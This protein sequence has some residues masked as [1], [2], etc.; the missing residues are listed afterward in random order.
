MPDLGDIQIDKPPEAT[1]GK[2]PVQRIVIPAVLVLLAIAG[3]ALYFLLPSDQPPQ[4]PTVTETVAP[5]EPALVPTAPEPAPEAPPDDAPLLLPILDESD[6]V[7][8]ELA[9]VISTNPQLAAWLASDDLV[10]TFAVTVENV[11]DGA[12][13]SEHLEVLKP[14]DRFVTREDDGQT[15]IDERSYSRYDGLAAVVASLDADG[16]ARL[17]RNLEPLLGDAYRELGHPDADFDEA[18]EGA[19]RTLLETPVVEGRVTLLPRGV[20]HEFV[21]PNLETLDAAQKQLI[22][23]GPS[24]MR[25]VQ[26]KLR[27]IAGALDIPAE[28]L[29]KPTVYRP[30]ELR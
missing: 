20:Y 1:T 8:R 10:R 3:L 28:R 11:A 30:T 24:N 13:P 23:I 2:E 7:V 4:E 12:N 18:F 25:T 26:R 15:I 14:R 5:D 27:E 22:A 6:T 21:D 19:L 17:Y 9:S 16:C 29:P